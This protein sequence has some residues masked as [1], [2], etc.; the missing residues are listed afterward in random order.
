MAKIKRSKPETFKSCFYMY[1]NIPKFE[2]FEPTKDVDSGLIT[3]YKKNYAELSDEEF[4]DM[5]IF[6]KLDNL[7]NIYLIEIQ[8]RTFWPIK[9]MNH[10]TIVIVIRLLLI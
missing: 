1:N 7:C 4:I 10:Y 3:K 6:C 2:L 5:L 9:F 8:W